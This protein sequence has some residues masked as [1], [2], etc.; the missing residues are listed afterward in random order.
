MTGDHNRARR[1]KPATLTNRA[2]PRAR[3]PDGPTCE[4]C[5]PARV[6]VGRIDAQTMFAARMRRSRVALDRPK[7]PGEL[8]ETKLVGLAGP[9]G[10]HTAGRSHK[11]HPRRTARSPLGPAGERVPAADAQ[12][13]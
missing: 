2:W 8:F 1:R 10:R 6:L 3:R 12:R 7:A 13:R 5:P 11:R 4:G 9:E